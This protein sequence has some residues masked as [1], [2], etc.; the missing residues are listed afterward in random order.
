MVE[1]E[2]GVTHTYPGNYRNFLKL[3]EDRVR[4]AMERWEARQKEI[5]AIKGDI[6]R[7]RNTESAAVTVRAKERALKDMEPGG[8]K[9]VPRPFTAKARFA[10]RFPPAPRCS[11]EVIELEGVSHGYN[12]GTLFKDI[13]LCIERGDRIAIIGPNG[14][15]KSTLLRLIMGTERPRDGRAEIV[16]QNAVMRY[17]EQDQAN[18]LPLDKSV[19]QTV[20]D[21]SASTEHTYEE[22]RALLGKFMFNGEK[23]EDK[24]STLSGGEKAR[25]A[26]CRMLLEPCNLLLLDEPTNHLDIA[27]K[28]VLEEALQNFEGT[29]VMVSHDRFFLS[30]TAN[31]ILALE[32]GE[33]AIYEGDYKTYLEQQ[34]GGIA[35]KVAD[36]HLPGGATIKAAPKI[37]LQPDDEKKTEKKKKNF[38][39]K[40]GP[41]GNKMKGI[42]NAKRMSNV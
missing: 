13:E 42:K 9:H 28:E 40:G 15:G 24:L 26:L 32:N 30:Q 27:A 16:A 5:R 36:R 6:S 21:A 18:A 33:L 3:K 10:F 39:G 11:K 31:T 14:A 1:T 12:G 23:V 38:G 25:V 22:L 8:P 34:Q 17:F 41:S 29:V 2:Y 37:E 7:L 35:E 20:Q 4:L 19:L